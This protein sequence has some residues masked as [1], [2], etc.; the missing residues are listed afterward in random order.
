LK[1]KAKSQMP[2][3]S[4]RGTALIVVMWVLAIVSLIVSSFAFEMQ[5]ESRV[6][7]MQRKRFKADQL[8]LAGV[9]IAK[10]MMAFEEENPSEERIYDDPWL[11]E[12]SKIT[13]GIPV[14]YTKQTSNGLIRVTIDYEKGRRNISQLSEDGW[15]ELFVQTGVPNVDWDALLGCLT[16]WEDENDLHQLNGAESDDAFYRERGY[17]CKNAPLDTV[18][19]LLLIKGWTEGILYGSSQGADDAVLETPMTGVASHLTTWGNGKVNPNSASREVLSSLYIEEE[20]I[21]AILEARLGLDGEEGTEDDGLT[22]EDFAALGLNNDQFTL[23]PE[24]V[25]VSAEGE[26]GGVISR[27]DSVFKLGEKGPTALFW[28]E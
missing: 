15:R 9:E 13:D 17:E 21:D 24:Y 12:A 11:A 18:D 22:Q 23:K 19:E 20:L 26:V 6:V 4:R 7:T 16:D 28:Q 8:A 5:L 1:P 25:N 14:R 27:I 10:A 2:K 3:A